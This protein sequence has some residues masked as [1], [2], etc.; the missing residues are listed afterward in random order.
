VDISLDVPSLEAES[1]KAEG[2]EGCVPRGV[3]GGRGGVGGSVDLDDEVGRWCEKVD[4]EAPKGHLAPKADPEGGAAKMVP[5][6]ALGGSGSRA[7]RASAGD[8]VRG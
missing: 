1:A 7:K 5:K 3:V 6:D 2:G 4:D 8:E